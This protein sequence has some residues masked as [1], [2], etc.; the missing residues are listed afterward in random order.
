MNTSK[1]N[2]EV[3]AAKDDCYTHFAPQIQKALWQESLFHLKMGSNMSKSTLDS[4]VPIKKIEHINVNH[5]GKL[6]LSEIEHSFKMKDNI[7]PSAIGSSNA[8]AQLESKVTTSVTD[9]K[10]SG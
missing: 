4:G 8:F 10:T 9:A 2:F 5:E 6:L 3:N 7:N 1:E